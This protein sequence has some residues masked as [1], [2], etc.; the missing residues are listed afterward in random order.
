MKRGR[1]EDSK[2]KRQ[3]ATKE[4]E[5]RK[6]GKSEKAR[7]QPRERERERER[8]C[9]CVCVDAVGV[10]RQ[11][12]SFERRIVSELRRKMSI[13]ACDAWFRLFI[14]HQIVVIRIRFT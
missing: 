13:C 8:V 11:E 5:R 12:W 14:S 3:K 10:V 7:G 1:R 2:E 4:R 9:V 6:K